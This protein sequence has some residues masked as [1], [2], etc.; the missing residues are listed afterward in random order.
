MGTEWPHVDTVLAF[1]GQ[2]H[3]DYLV[4]DHST[5]LDMA[6]KGQDRL[7]RGFPEITM[8]FHSSVR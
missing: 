1:E 3:S 4:S 2:E 7:R 8:A 6:K 5:L